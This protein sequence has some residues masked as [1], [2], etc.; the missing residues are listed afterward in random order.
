MATIVEIYN[1]L[2]NNLLSVR[3]D[4]AVNPG[5]SISDSFLGPTSYVLYKNRVSL[6]YNKALQ[7][8]FTIQLLLANDSAIEVIAN[9]ELKTTDEVI[10]DI[11]DFIDKIAD[12]YRLTRYPAVNANGFVSFGRID[13]PSQ[14]I[15]IPAGTQIKTAEN[16]QYTT[17]ETVVMNTTDTDLYDA[18]SNLYIVQVPV[19]ANEAGIIGNTLSGTITQFI[20]NIAG[21][22]YVFNRDAFAN[23]LDEE[24]NDSLIER[25][26]VRLSGNTFGTLDGYK[27]LI[28]NNFRTV[29][30]ILV[31]SSG[32]PLMQRNSGLGGAVDIWVLDESAPTVV[33]ENGV[34][35]NYK[36]GPYDAYI[37]NNQPLAE[38][39]ISPNPFYNV[40]DTGELAH[41][42]VQ[43]A[44]VYF[45]PPGSGG[46]VPPLDFTYSYYAI[47]PAIQEFLNLPENAIL[48][49]TI[50]K[51]NAI[52]SMALVKKAIE[53]PVN[54][55]ATI[56]LSTGPNI[57]ATTVIAQCQTAIADYVANLLLGESL[58]QSDIIGI[59]ENVPGVNGAVTPINNFNFVGEIIA[60][61]NILT[62][63]R[64]EY[65]RA[66]SINVSL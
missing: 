18:E 14:N 64:N 35:F 59:L 16:K 20:N 28:L 1:E 6:D 17:T 39:L 61:V 50:K 7:T 10:S 19:E 40:A 22:N 25:I 8:L 52:E 31:V 4:L 63:E 58:N 27:N 47:I 13:P 12:N 57:N 53:K 24:N 3:R 33:V 29:R 60:Q 36:E 43:N 11:T 9:A 5:S 44:G 23:G 30:D 66:N 37:F 49:N 45:Y 2:K 48:G 32:D 26:K 34:S 55:A 62:V 38:V 41:S 21:L 65:I 15:T 54:I 42:Y 46:P 56:T 51:E